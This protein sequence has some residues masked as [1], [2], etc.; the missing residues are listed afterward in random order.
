M[1]ITDAFEHELRAVATFRKVASARARERG[2]KVSKLRKIVHGLNKHRGTASQ[3]TNTRIHE[4]DP[5]GKNTREL[6][7][8]LKF[9][10]LEIVAALT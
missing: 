10:T 4:Y 2:G 5:P 9:V 7:Y 1:S 6:G 8:L 3:S